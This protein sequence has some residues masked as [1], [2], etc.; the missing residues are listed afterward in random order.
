MILSVKIT[1]RTVL[2][3]LGKV[4]KGE[5]LTGSGCT[6][7]ITVVGGLCPG[8]MISYIGNIVGDRLE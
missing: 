6:A 1:L 7:T 2:Q 8:V 5:K 3:N 4:R